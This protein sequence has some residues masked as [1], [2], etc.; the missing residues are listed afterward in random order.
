LRS[1][2]GV[3]VGISIRDHLCTAES[4]A[5][6]AGLSCAP[7]T[8]FVSSSDM[9]WCDGGYGFPGGGDAPG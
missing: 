2:A 5:I 4:A 9:C 7:D 3:T 6:S 8:A 1:R